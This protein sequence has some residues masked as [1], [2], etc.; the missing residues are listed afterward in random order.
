MLDDTQNAGADAVLEMAVFMNDHLV[1]IT[2]D[3]RHPDA[4]IPCN[5]RIGASLG[6]GLIN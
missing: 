2:L 3:S 5:V 1:V 6:S 4:V